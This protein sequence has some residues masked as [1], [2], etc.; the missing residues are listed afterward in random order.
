MENM[1]DIA[2]LI[3]RG[4]GPEETARLHNEQVRQLYRHGSVGIVAT[5][6]NAA[7]LCYIQWRVI[8]HAVLLAWFSAVFLITLIRAIYI[9]K[10]HQTAPTS[11]AAQGW[12]T[13]FI[14]GLGISGIA[15]GAAGI[16]LFP[17]QDIIHQ[18]FPAAVLGGM[19]AGAAST[20]S[21]LKLAFFA[22]SLPAL[23]PIIVKFFSLSDKLHISLGLMLLLFLILMTVT[24]V[25]SHKMFVTSL[26]LRFENRDLVRY[27][28]KA[29]EKAEGMNVKLEVEIIE[30]KKAEEEL[31][32]HQEK[33]ETTVEERT[34]ELKAANR[35]LQIKIDERKQAADALRESEE[36]YRL[37]VENAN[38][39]IFLVQDDVVKFANP[40]LFKISGYSPQELTTLPFLHLIHAEDRGCFL[41]KTKTREGEDVSGH[42]TVRM[43]SKSGKELFVSIGRVFIRWEG[44]SAAL[45]FLRDITAQ[46]KLETELQLAQKMK[47][48]GTLAGGIAHDFNNLLMGIQGNVTLMLDEHGPEHH[49][50]EKLKHIEQYVQSCTT[51]TNQ[52]LGFARG[53]KY[54]VLPTDLNELI[55]N[56]SFMF[57]RTRKEIKIITQFQ[58]DLR[59][60]EVDPGQ[61]EQVLLNLYINAWQAMPEGGELFI[62]TENVLLE[63]PISQTYDVTPGN[64]VKVAVR[65]TGMGID[66]KIRLRI[67]DP[68]FTTK[69]MGRGTGL[70]LASAYGI[71]KSH[72]GIITIE[73]EEGKGT[74]FYLFLPASEKSVPPVESGSKKTLAAAGMI[75]LVDDEDIMIDVGTRMLQRL[76]FE[77]KAA[78][79]G[80]EALQLFNAHRDHIDLVILDVVIPGMDGAR[81]YDYLKEMAPGIKVLLAS[82]Y[83]IDGKASEIMK[84][85]CS[86]FIQK[87]F[88]IKELS[89]KLVEILD[90]SCS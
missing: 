67:F 61:I 51:L 4:E 28:S 80:E 59:S 19:V 68:F 2:D 71:I 62:K 17:G 76:G 15:W 39:G 53:G 42:C 55:K 82:G 5:I 86:G 77:V 24:A 64:Y 29:K 13:G 31:K 69:E 38:D 1:D 36:K 87:P 89:A 43:I 7:I 34:L 27:L 6:M 49:D 3:E 35:E 16:L 74:T 30:R 60:V 75:L 21:A 12:G 40:S 66:E 14:T 47:S 41:E 22:Y 50:Y 58:E 25:R 90:F 9:Y 57:G 65:D 78:K 44:R 33:L 23:I 37:L 73:S 45:H 72:D 70:G 26:A 52:L 20:F 81:I 10:Y 85:G 18:I 46:K 56:T 84:K 83:S 11:A 32:R 54:E 79:S 88:G 63:T 48:I 8:S